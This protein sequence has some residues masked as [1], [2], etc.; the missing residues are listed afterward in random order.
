MRSLLIVLRKYRSLVWKVL[1]EIM[2][3]S[4]SVI[5]A[6]FVVLIHECG[7]PGIWVPIQEPK[8]IWP[9]IWPC[10]SVTILY[11]QSMSR[12]VN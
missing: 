6:I 10:S 11:F 3:I 7:C 2:E 9:W 5:H 4:F 12:S 8:V 1:Q